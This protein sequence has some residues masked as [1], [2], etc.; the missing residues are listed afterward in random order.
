V[1]GHPDGQGNVF[2]I[3]VDVGPEEDCL[4]LYRAG[5]VIGATDAETQVQADRATSTVIT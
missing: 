4:G 2:G 1:A 5:V 3:T